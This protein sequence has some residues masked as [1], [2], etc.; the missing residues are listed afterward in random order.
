MRFST[1]QDWLTWLESCHPAEIDLGLARIGEVASNLGID[2]SQSQLVTVAGTNGKGSCVAAL[3]AVLRRAGYSVGCYTSPHLLTYNE[4]VLVNDQQA[5]D[6]QLID[7]FQRIDQARGDI[8]LTYFE[9]GTLAAMD[10]FQRAGLDVVVLEVGLGGRL[11]AVNLVDP[12]IAIVTSIALDHQDWLGDD[13]QQIGREKAGI[14]R[15]GKPA[16]LGQADA[17]ASVGEVAEALG[18]RFYRAGQQFSGEVLADRW[19]W[20]GVDQWGEA[21]V[22]NDLPAVALPSTSVFV[23]LQALQLLPLVIPEQAYQALAD[24]ALAGRYQCFALAGAEVIVDVAHNPAAAQLLASRL[25]E[26]PV[27]GK[28]YALF[29]AMADKDVAGVIDTLR[30]VID[31]WVLTA[32]PATSRAMAVEDLVQILGDQNSLYSSFDDPVQAFNT[33]K[34]RLQS[35]DRLLVFGSFITVAAVL[36]TLMIS[37]GENNNE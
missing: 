32:L 26:T 2:L 24:I 8:S 15:A 1:L 3:N 17:P 10:I 6:Q 16:L 5:S 13:L 19:R 28:T 18:A 7:A 37:V 20:Q 4:R 31:S 14:F 23:A 30:P 11:D 9:F 25:A 22:L 36:P 12:D 33:L 21:V 34:D 35:G 27:T 29:G